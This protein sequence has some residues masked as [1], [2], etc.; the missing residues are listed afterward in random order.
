MGIRE[1]VQ[2]QTSG[3]WVIA[4]TSNDIQR[5]VA[6][7]YGNNQTFQLKTAQWYNN[8]E[9]CAVC[10]EQAPSTAPAA[11]VPSS[12]Q[13]PQSSQSA[14]PPSRLLSSPACPSS[15]YRPQG[16]SCWQSARTSPPAE[17]RSPFPPPHLHPP[18]PPPP[19]CG[20]SRRN[21][22]TPA[23]PRRPPP[24]RRTRRWRASR[25]GT[26]RRRRRRPRRGRGATPRAWRAGPT[27]TRRGTGRRSRSR[28]GGGA[29]ARGGGG[30]GGATG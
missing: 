3:L 27:R 5:R 17:N 8:E 21:S 13:C 23:L 1:W 18:L 30:G 4:Q 10:T 7:K 9:E 12:A 15:S 22:R 20:C 26:W 28:R 2:Y 6:V 25:R 14:L 16:S 11:A 19:Q 29:R 24:C